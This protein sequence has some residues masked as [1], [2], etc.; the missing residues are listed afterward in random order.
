MELRNRRNVYSITQPSQIEK[1][2][3]ST[4]L[5]EREVARIN[6][7]SLVDYSITQLYLTNTAT[8]K[9]PVLQLNQWQSTGR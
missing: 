4:C 9:V 3:A 7:P 1:V 8:H 6:W 5:Y 2:V